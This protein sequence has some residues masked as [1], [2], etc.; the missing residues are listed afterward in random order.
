MV[1][2][3]ENMI[4]L[5]SEAYWKVGQIVIE[6]RRTQNSTMYHSCFRLSALRF[7]LSKMNFDTP[8][9]HIVEEPATDCCLYVGVV[10]TMEQMLMV[11]IV[12]CSCQMERDEYFS[13]SRLFS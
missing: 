4:C 7:L 1:M 11:H 2:S 13:M 5:M 10:D 8:V 3:S 9:L 12:E 6:E